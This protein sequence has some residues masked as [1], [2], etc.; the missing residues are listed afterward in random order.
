M[1][2]PHPFPR[3]ELSSQREHAGPF[4][5]GSSAPAR[6]RPRQHQGYSRAGDAIG[7]GHSSLTKILLNR[8]NVDKMNIEKIDEAAHRT[9][10]TKRAAWL[11][12]AHAETV[13][14]RVAR[15]P[16]HAARQVGARVS[17]PAA[18]PTATPEAKNT[19]AHLGQLGSRRASF[20][21]RVRTPALRPFRQHARQSARFLAE[22]QSGLTSAAT[23]LRGRLRKGRAAC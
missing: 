7:G 5:A 15:P 17:S 11:G 2:F 9:K 12:V 22:N 13:K 8:K 23:A 16:T 4:G 14:G 10:S 20:P 6:G 19:Q 3:N 18:A 1:V 21:L